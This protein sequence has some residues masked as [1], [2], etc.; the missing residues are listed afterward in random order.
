V[1]LARGIDQILPHPGDPRLYEPAVSSASDYVALAEQANGPIPRPV[2]YSY[3]WGD[4]LTELRDRAPDARIINLETSITRNAIHLPKGINYRMNPRNIP[5]L[6]AADIDCCVLANNHVLDWNR[7]GLLE[8]LQT[9]DAAGI[10]TAGAGRNAATAKAPA[11]IPFGGPGPGRVLIVGFGSQ[12]SGIPPDWAAE[13]NQPGLNLLPDLSERTLDRIAETVGAWKRSGDVLVASIHWGGN[14]GYRVSADQRRFAHGLIDRAGFDVIHGHSSHHPKGIEFYNDR[15]ILYGCGDF[16][17][18]YEGISGYE[19]FR[20]DLVIMYLP[21]F[22]FATGRLLDLTLVPFRIRNFR[23]NRASEQETAWLLEM[24]QRESSAFG[25][26]VVMA[27]DN[28]LRV[29]RP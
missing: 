29:L 13:E 18:D 5:C 23:L 16:L 14:W 22:A 2:D 25:C 10:R 12:T 19:Q 15:L 17:N 6:T 20:G 3:V 7:A 1:M 8:T 11:I 9:L 4:A 28:S 21:T 24:L 27:G 26:R